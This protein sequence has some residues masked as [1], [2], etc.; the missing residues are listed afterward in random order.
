M[1]T[2]NELSGKTGQSKKEK[3]MSSTLTVEPENRKKKTLPYELK[4][5]LQ[6]HTSGVICHYEMNHSD[7]PY[8]KGLRD[9][10]VPGADELI[11]FIEKHETV[12]LNE[13][14]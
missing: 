4:L 10:D 11:E 6:K 7:L 3:K 9:A 13:Q 5:I 8:L 2:Q 12:I 14:F 1:Q